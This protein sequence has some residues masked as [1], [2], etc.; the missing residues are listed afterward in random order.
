MGEDSP[1]SLRG[2]SD[3]PLEHRNLERVHPR[4]AQAQAGVQLVR[5][6]KLDPGSLTYTTEV[7]VPCG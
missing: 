6:G 3:T 5:A 7:T 2:T 1:S 4:K